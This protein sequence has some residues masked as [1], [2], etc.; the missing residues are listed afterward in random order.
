MSGVLLP[1]SRII[2]NLSRQR[3][4]YNENAK[5]A[6]N[7]KVYIRRLFLEEQQWLLERI[8]QQVRSQTQAG[9]LLADRS[10]MEEEIKEMARDPDIQ[11]EIAAINREFARTKR[12]GL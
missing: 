3:R 1:K 7:R 10:Y 2:Q 4:E 9:D 6:R 12:D 8:S 5:R 11:A